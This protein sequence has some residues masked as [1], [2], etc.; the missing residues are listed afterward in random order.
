ML[1]MME[2]PLIRIGVIFLSLALT[3]IS[4]EALIKEA[5]DEFCTIS[6][7]GVING[8]VSPPKQI[9]RYDSGCI[10]SLDGGFK[11]KVVPVEK[12][13][14]KNILD[15]HLKS[16]TFVRTILNNTSFTGRAEMD[17]C[18][19]TPTSKRISKFNRFQLAYLIHTKRTAN[20]CENAVRVTS[21]STRGKYG[22]WI[23]I[24]RDSGTKTVISIIMQWHGR[25]DR[26]VYKDQ[27]GIHE[28]NDSL[29]SITNYV[30]LTR[31]INTYNNVLRDG[32][33]FDQGGYPPLSVWI[34]KYNLVVLARYD[35]RKYDDKSI[36][37][38]ADYATIPL[39][40]P[41]KCLDKLTEKLFL[42]VIHREPLHNWI[43]KW[44]HLKLTIDW[45]PIG[46]NSSVSIFKNGRKVKSWE[47]LLGRHDKNGPYMKYG[48]YA[49]KYSKNFKL[50]VAYAFSDIDN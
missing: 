27:T 10:F 49:N 32:G 15:A 40:K 24:P 20:Y 47:G 17:F 34:Y 22:G 29:P 42:T 18:F 25:P 16:F 37:C 23:M 12:S 6:P 31:A 41:K 7:V 38:E 14:D 33:K 28:L 21:K 30:S 36:R 44:N 3:K 35:N 9:V 26:L 48:I 1:K 8:K 4:E 19:T 11:R 5:N 50:K 2:K 13:G 45:R 43:D 39:N 46:V